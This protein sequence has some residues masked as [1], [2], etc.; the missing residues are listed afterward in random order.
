MFVSGKKGNQLNFKDKVDYINYNGED[1]ME[2]YGYESFI[3]E[4]LLLSRDIL[5]K[6]LF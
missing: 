1:Q 6:L 3:K 5:W 2:I 4:T